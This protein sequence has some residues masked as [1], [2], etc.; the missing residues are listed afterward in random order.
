[1]ERLLIIL[2]QRLSSM[3][4]LGLTCLSILTFIVA[5]LFLSA[6]QRYGHSLSVQQYVIVTTIALIF[7]VGALFY[8]TW[9]W[10]SDRFNGPR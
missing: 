4:A 2:V 3:T 1:M 8:F 9:A 5:I 7:S 10:V 6:Q